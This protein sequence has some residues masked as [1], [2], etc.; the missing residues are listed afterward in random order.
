M[1][2][3]VCPVLIA[4]VLIGCHNKVTKHT[5]KIRVPK[6]LYEAHKLKIKD[7]IR[8]MIND[9]KPPYNQPQYDSETVAIV[10][11]IIYGPDKSKLFFIVITKDSD[12]KI[13]G[14]GRQ[15]QFHF[16]A[17]CFVAQ[18]E[19][20][21]ITRISWFSPLNLSWYKTYSAASGKFRNFYLYNLAGSQESFQYNV[22]D[23]RFWTDNNVWSG[24][25]NYTQVFQDD[26]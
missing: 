26:R 23:V 1:K 22:E 21:S 19:D 24:I 16:N 18:V 17:R 15:D 9:H 13:D 25:H 4:L 3:F 14:N 8:I 7:E 11:T 20:T 12:A 5:Y 6:N 10:D 2:T